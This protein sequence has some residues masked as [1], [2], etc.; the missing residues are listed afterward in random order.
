MLGRRGSRKSH[1]IARTCP[2]PDIHSPVCF[3][4]DKLSAVNDGYAY[5]EA[6]LLPFSFRRTS[7]G[8]NRGVLLRKT[9]PGDSVQGGKRLVAIARANWNGT[10]VHAWRVFK[11]PALGARRGA[12][13]STPC[14][15]R[16]ITGAHISA[17]ASLNRGTCF[18][19]FFIF[20]SVNESGM[21]MAFPC[22]PI[23]VYFNCSPSILSTVLWN[24]PNAVLLFLKK[25][26]VLHRAENRHS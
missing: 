13:C 2:Y 3:Y 4:H 7:K 21:I 11:R 9:Y 23:R 15:T 6:I 14:N 10:P 20:S 26:E 24:I 1:I 19:E 17:L 8:N 22:T 12:S 5:T 18:R 16:V 25:I